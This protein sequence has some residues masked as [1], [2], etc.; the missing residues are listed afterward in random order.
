MKLH[1]ISR[2]QLAFCV[3]FILMALV[4]FIGAFY[5]TYHALICGMSIVMLIVC[6]N[7]KSW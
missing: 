3:I 7:E 5:N 6:Y 1:F 4:C 2:M